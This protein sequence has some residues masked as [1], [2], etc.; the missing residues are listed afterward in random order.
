MKRVIP[1]ILLLALLCSGCGSCGDEV[2]S[3]SIGPD[4]ASKA[5]L[6]TRNCGATTDFSTIVS[7]HRP[8]NSF[9]DEGD[10][11]FVAK[12][13]GNIQLKWI[14]AK[15]LEI[16]CE[17]RERKYVFRRVTALGDIDISYR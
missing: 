3:E 2:T 13:Q 15:A 11:V 16:H 14:S 7:I 8:D 1:V 5:T 12:G 6:F 17:G 10:F 4:R 9:S